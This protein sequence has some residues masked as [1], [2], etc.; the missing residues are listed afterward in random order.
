MALRGD[1]V[2]DQEVEIAETCRKEESVGKGAERDTVLAAPAC[3]GI[4]GDHAISIDLAFA[5]RVVELWSLR[6]NND[7][8]V[9]KLSEVDAWLADHRRTIGRDGRDVTND[10][11]WQAARADLGNRDHGHTNPVREGDPAIHPRRRLLR[12]IWVQLT[13]REHDESLLTIDGVAVNIDVGK[14]VVLTNGLQLV[15]GL[16][17]R[18]IIPETSVRKRLS[19][20]GD[21]IR[22]KG[23][24]AVVLQLAPTIKAEGETRHL[25]VVGYVWLLKGELVRLHLEAL[26][27]LRVETTEHTRRTEPDECGEGE[28]PDGARQ[29]SA[30]QECS[31]DRGDG[32]KDV[33]TWKSCGVIGIGDSG[34]NT[35]VRIDQLQLVQLIPI[36]RGE[37][38]ATDHQCKVEAREC[39]NES[40]TSGTYRR[41][42]SERRRKRSC[43]QKRDTDPLRKAQDWEFKEVEGDVAT[44]DWVNDR[45]AARIEGDRVLPE[46][47]RLPVRS[48][49]CANEE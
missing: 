34:G 29:R 25:Q 42:I 41:E 36:G 30:N 9:I 14:V 19:I 24:F 16:L 8:V 27:K 21:R 18:S 40:E 39:S 28:R 26:D 49:L 3:G 17:Q 45:G 5:N 46:A 6:A 43:K 44:K 11:T 48:N 38:D 15:K 47:D 4:T 32:R 22:S 1:L 2:A 35:R 33:E 12:A 23:C 31:G 13:C 37:Q 7:P 20:R 10:Q